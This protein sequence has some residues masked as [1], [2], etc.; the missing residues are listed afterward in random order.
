LSIKG[1]TGAGRLHWRSG[2][3]RFAREHVKNLRHNLVETWD[4]R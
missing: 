2:F 4:G 1:L 3:C